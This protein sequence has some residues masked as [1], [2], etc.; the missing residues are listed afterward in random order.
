MMKEFQ[1]D[2]T[3][4]QFSP[5]SKHSRFHYKDRP[6][7]TAQENIRGLLSESY[8]RVNT[9]CLKMYNSPTLN[10]TVHIVTSVPE[11]FQ[12]VLKIA[13]LRKY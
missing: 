10:R 1:L 4:S 12:E 13:R 6:V 7:D 3:K 5:H 8:Q 11:T 2:N 9:P